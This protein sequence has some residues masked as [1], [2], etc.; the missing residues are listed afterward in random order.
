MPPNL[1]EL[2]DMIRRTTGKYCHAYPNKPRVYEF[3]ENIAAFD[4]RN[5]LTKYDYVIQNQVMNYRGKIIGFNILN[6]AEDKIAIFIPTYPSA[7]MKDVKTIYTDDIQWLDY[8]STYTRLNNISN[9]TKGGILCK[10]FKRVIEDALIVGILTETNQ[11][12]QIDPSVPNTIEDELAEHAINGSNYKEYVSIDKTLSV[13]KT[14]DSKR[15]ETIQNISLETHFY[16]TFRNQIRILLNEYANKE[17]RDKLIEIIDNPRYLYQVKLKKMDI[18]LK[19][20]LRNAVSFDNFNQDILTSLRQFSAFVTDNDTKKYCLVKKNMLCIPKNNLISGAGNEA[21]YFARIA[22]ELL[23][24]K[25]VRLFML[26]PKRYLNITNV[27]YKITDHEIILLQSLLDG[28]YFDDLIPFD[29]NKYVQN[30]TYDIANPATIGQHY[31][32]EIS[33]SSQ[34]MFHSKTIGL[35]E[36]SSECVKQTG[37]VIEN[38]IWN[39]PIQA[40][41]TILHNTILCSFYVIIYIL[42]KHA[43]V[44]VSVH[45]VKIHLWKAYK[46]EFDKKTNTLKIFHILEKQGK[47]KLIANAKINTD[48]FEDIIMSENYALTNLDLWLLASKLNLPI[49]IFAE[50][51]IKNLGVSDKWLVLGGE[52]DN[53]KYYFVRCSGKDMKDNI[54]ENYSLI[55]PAVMLKDMQVP[56]Q[57]KTFD[58]YIQKYTIGIKI[59]R[60]KPVV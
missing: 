54:D 18:L 29:T 58:E 45:D 35:R 32:N 2:F 55:T 20:L 13:G 49:V 9:K 33:L 24:Y 15:V 39:F 59:V 48:V 43:N 60:P 11:F 26:E 25:R 31:S 53:D 50:S 38:G 41:E 37:K 21:L 19:Y 8:H 22:D 56:M 42:K 1:V 23:R 52:I 16:I 27:D 34:H 12:I 30:I 6:G 46:E 40:K 57:K 3:K 5:I 10:P 44:D 51:N 4:I 14:H 17:V 7:A 36:F 47:N 28:D